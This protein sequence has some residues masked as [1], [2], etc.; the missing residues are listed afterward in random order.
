MSLI[1]PL[2]PGPLDIVG[3]I[4]GEIDALTELLSH[5][6]YGPDGAHPDG[7]TLVFVGDYCDRGPDSPAVLARIAQLHANG[8][9]LAVLGNHE[10]NLLRDDPKDG[11]G[12]YF[13][14]RV[15]SDEPKYAPFARPGSAERAA[16]RAFLAPLPVALER[17]DLRIVH[18][19]WQTAAVDAARQLAPGSARSAYD[20][21]EDE[22]REQARSSDIAVRMKKEHQRWPHSL[23]QGERR[24]PFLR[25]HGENELLKAMFN[26]LKVL[27]SGV[28]RL[29]THPF[30]A[31]GKWRFVEREAWWDSYADAQAVVVGHYWRRPFV[32]NPLASTNEE[33]SLFGDAPPFGWHGLRHN[34]FCVDYSV[35]ARWSARKVGMPVG[36]QCKLAALRWPERT[37][38]FDDGSTV[39]TTGF[40]NA[41]VAAVSRTALAVDP[42]HAAAQPRAA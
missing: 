30:Y 41:G 18:A 20:R 14:E 10:I 23:E 11:S 37:L 26:P 4:H 38:M 22:V 19:A 5:L 25:A 32:P 2:P 7:R 17:A 15:A 9:A 29:G 13:D 42:A 24:P 27:T 28:E 3:D 21:W 16:I 35:G 1:H 6:G 33:T 8:H 39:A 36:A 34:V 40:G 12:W 31:G